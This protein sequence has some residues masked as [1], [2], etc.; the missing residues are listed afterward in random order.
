MKKLVSFLL[1]ALILLMPIAS[2]C[3]SDNLIGS[4]YIYVDATKYPELSQLSNY[5]DSAFT[6]YTFLEN[7]TIMWLE[8]DVKDGN[9]TPTYNACGRWE[10]GEEKNNYKY[11]MIGIGEGTMI[12]KNDGL[13]INI[14]Q[15]NIAVRFRRIFT[16]N[17][18]T[19]FKLQ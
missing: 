12:L 4:W 5:N 14:P 2:I 17:P 11:S 8:N 16:F 9:A 13:T 3:E 19:D 18:Y 6:V 7:G 1:A 10:K 15:N